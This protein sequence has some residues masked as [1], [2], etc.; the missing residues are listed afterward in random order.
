MSYGAKL[1]ISTVTGLLAVVVAVP[2]HVTAQ[3]QQHVYLISDTADYATMIY[4]GLRGILYQDGAY[5]DTVDVS[6]GVQHVPGGILFLPVR[7][8]DRDNIDCARDGLCSD[9]T[10]YMFYNGREGTALH[11][12]VPELLDH[13]SSPSVIDSLLYFWGIA[14]HPEGG[15]T[16]SAMRHDL[17]VSRTDSTYLYR[18]ALATDNPWHFRR[19]QQEG[20][21]I[22]FA[23]FQRV[24]W[25][26][27]SL[28]LVR[29]SSSAG[30][31]LT[32]P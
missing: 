11:E 21:L 15:Y 22:R 32:H 5:L 30:S 12:L 29:D 2:S 16:I 7:V 31:R 19:P 13:W 18:D 14:R 25:L 8:Y 23:T 17:A 1:V 20:A 4:G 3:E 24:V 9:F 27:P 28:E 6:F 26:T 10:N